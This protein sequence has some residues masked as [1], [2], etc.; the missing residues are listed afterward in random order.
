MICASHLAG[1]N[2]QRK[3]YSLAGEFYEITGKISKELV[4]TLGTV[5]SYRDFA[6][7]CDGMASLHETLGDLKKAAG[8]RIYE[9]EARKSAARITGASRDELSLAECYD[10]LG[11][12][13]RKMGKPAEALTQY[14]AAYQM[15]KQLCGTLKNS[16][17]LFGVYCSC[18]YI[19]ETL[20]EMGSM[21]D[22]RAC[23]LDSIAICEQMVTAEETVPNLHALGTAY[24]EA[25]K[26]MAEAEQ[27]RLLEKAAALYEK[28]CGMEPE[29]K[30][31]QSNLAVLREHL[32]E[33]E[34]R[35]N[36]RGGFLKKLFGKK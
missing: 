22:A 11:D 15:K 20:A 23:Y 3:N 16:K 10:G 6:V 32:E 2:M 36:K 33:E 12:L 31:F 26:V 1:I 7:S 24:V 17:T 5:E 13:F 18:S 9:L 34:K 14:Q 28:L 4:D 21:K 25:A 30:T 27:I 29:N 19:A 8:L 35:Q